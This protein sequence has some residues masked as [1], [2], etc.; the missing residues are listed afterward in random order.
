MP[1]SN[2]KWL[3]LALRALFLT[4]SSS[5]SALLATAALNTSDS[6]NKFWN[7]SGVL[8]FSKGALN[9][10]NRASLEAS[11]II[12]WKPLAKAQECKGAKAKAS[13]NI[14]V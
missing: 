13:K 8:S 14:N 9:K 10:A 7:V 1:K 6:F 2:I 4:G 11:G 5:E 3:N 12:R